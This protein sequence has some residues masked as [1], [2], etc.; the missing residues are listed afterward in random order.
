LAGTPDTTQVPFVL[1]TCDYTLLGDEYAAAGAYRST[2]PTLL[3]SLVGQDYG[4]I[5]LIITIIIGIA[6]ATCTA[7]APGSTAAQWL[8]THFLE[9][10]K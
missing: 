5:V 8:S 1:A 10:F 7:L 9:Y 4:K 2:E 6:A 3:G